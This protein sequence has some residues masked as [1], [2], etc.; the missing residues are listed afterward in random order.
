MSLAWDQLF[1]T[2]WELFGVITGTLSVALLIPVMFPRLQYLNWIASVLSAVVYTYIFTDYKLYG[3]AA[4]QVYFVIFSLLGMWTWRG[5]FLGRDV[6]DEIPITFAPIREVLKS[7]VVALAA[8]V[9]VYPILQHYGD[10]S[11]FWDGLMVCLSGAAI[12]LQVKKY[13]ENWMLWIAVDLIAVPLHASNGLQA[14]ALLYGLYF[15]MCLLGLREWNIAA[16]KH[17]IEKHRYV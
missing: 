1:T 14:T 3:N 17:A 9:F 12:W 6:A 4:L 10:A 2:R 15:L 8:L 5:Q 11:A 13:V 7:V 16:N